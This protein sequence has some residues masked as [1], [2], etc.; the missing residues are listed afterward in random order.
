MVESENDCCKKSHSLGMYNDQVYQI[1][2]RP[3]QLHSNSDSNSCMSGILLDSWLL[4]PQYILLIGAAIALACIVLFR[5]DSRL[6][7]ISFVILW[8]L[9][10]AWR[11]AISSPVGDPNQ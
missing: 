7:L 1:T 5:Y 4:L 6:M 9:L 11:F 8:L 10:G 3:A 2:I